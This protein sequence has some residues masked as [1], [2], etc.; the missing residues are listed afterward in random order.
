MLTKRTLLILAMVTSCVTGWAEKKADSGKTVVE[1]STKNAI[2]L[3]TSTPPKLPAK[4]ELP[5]KAKLDFGKRRIERPTE[6]L[7]A[8]Q[9]LGVPRSAPEPRPTTP[10]AENPKAEPGKVRWHADFEAARAAS[11]KSR[12]PVLLFQMM[13]NLDDRFC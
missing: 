13:G 4:L 6:R 1:T 5:P 9:A 2:E 7:L 11:R 8:E 12:R 10:A 3:S